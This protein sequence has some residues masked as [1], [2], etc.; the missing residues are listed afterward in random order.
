[1]RG[2][3]RERGQRAP[4]ADRANLGGPARGGAESD[5]SDRAGRERLWAAMVESGE[6]LEDL[7]RLPDFSAN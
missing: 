3:E 7:N 6:V 5:E 4:D 1:M 2:D